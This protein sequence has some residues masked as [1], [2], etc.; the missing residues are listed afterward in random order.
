[1]PP[2]A[3]APAG[4]NRVAT[5]ETLQRNW[6]AWTGSFPEFMRQLDQRRT[7]YLSH[8]K[9][10]TVERCPRCYFQQYILGEQPSSDA[11]TT[12]VAFHQAA[13]AF[14]EATRAGR[15]KPVPGRT[16]PAL[17]GP[18]GAQQTAVLE[19]RLPDHAAERLGRV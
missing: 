9:V 18:P 4:N 13:A 16:A 15:R 17:A 11:L 12:G 1:M 14:Y 10:A 5:A 3:T 19:Q 7:P 6:R 8:S 2:G